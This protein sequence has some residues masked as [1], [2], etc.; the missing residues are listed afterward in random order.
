MQHQCL[1]HASIPRSLETTDN[2][3][4][5]LKNTQGFNPFKP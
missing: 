2:Y 1:S 3:I 4:E 5:L